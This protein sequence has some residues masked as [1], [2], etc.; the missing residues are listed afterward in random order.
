M[1]TRTAYRLTGD[2]TA[3]LSDAASVLPAVRR[4]LTSTSPSDVESACG[5]ISSWLESGPLPGSSREFSAGKSRFTLSRV[6][7]NPS[8]P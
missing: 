3:T 7:L 6:I 4:N 8:K 2:L 5:E 1:K